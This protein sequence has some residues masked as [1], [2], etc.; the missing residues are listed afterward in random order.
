MREPGGHEHRPG[1]VG[2]AQQRIERA[3]EPPVGGQV[4]GDD[5]VPVLGADMADRR[6]GAGDSGIT[7]QDVELA[8]ALVDCRAEAVDR[9]PIG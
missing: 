8:P 7:D 2:L 6:Q 9:P 4:D 1:S 5:L 3:D